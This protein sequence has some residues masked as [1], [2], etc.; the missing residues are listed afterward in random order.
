M[1]RINQVKEWLREAQIRNPKNKITWRECKE[2]VQKAMIQLHCSERLAKE[3]MKIAHM[4]ISE[5][6]TKF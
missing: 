6:Q 4:M 3:Y 5:Q 1:E 2:V